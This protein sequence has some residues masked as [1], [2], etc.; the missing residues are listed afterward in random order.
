MN[1][2][3]I[4][5]VQDYKHTKINVN[6]STHMQESN[7]QAGSI[8]VKDIMTTQREQRPF[9]WKIQR[10][11]SGPG[12]STAGDMYVSMRIHP[13]SCCIFPLKVATALLI[14]SRKDTVRA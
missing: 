5:T 1:A 6:G 9:C 13:K 11:A 12:K 4:I 3:E 10:R 8:W 14:G 7:S 2:A